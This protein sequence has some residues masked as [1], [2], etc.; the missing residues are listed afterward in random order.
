M[1]YGIHGR[2]IAVLLCCCIMVVSRT[3]VNVTAQ[4]TQLA[5]GKCGAQ[6]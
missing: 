5:S 3:E 1:P 2:S 4:V 6:M